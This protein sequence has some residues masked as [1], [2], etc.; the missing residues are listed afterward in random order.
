VP[1]ELAR[2]S[3]GQ[4]IEIP[5]LLV[6]VGVALLY[7]AVV[8]GSLGDRIPGRG[9]VRPR[10][11]AAFLTALGLL[12]LG[13]GGPLDV[14]AD[15]YLY[16][17][18]MTQH[19]LEAFGAA[20]LLLLGTPDW[21]VRPLWR[22]RLGG[23]LRFLT[24]PLVGMALFQ[25]VMALTA[26]PRFYDLIETSDAMH[27][28]YHAALLVTAL[29]AWWPFLSPLAE[30]PRMH[31]GMQMLMITVSGLPML[32]TFAPIAL[33]T[34]PFYPYYARVPRVF[35]LSQVADQQLGAIIMLTG[36]HVVAAVQFLEAFGQWVRQEQVGRIDA[37]PRR[38]ARPEGAGRVLTL[39]RPEWTT[40]E[41]DAGE[42]TTP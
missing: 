25:A 37:D 34:A 30:S 3:V 42:S 12:Y 7:L 5:V 1:P 15:G 20:P 27:F 31:P 22:S 16:S 11:V 9:P 41:A 29:G 35:G 21:L 36:A 14:L 13:F 40:P 24:R 19:F 39:A 6:N 17:A 26:W 28:G 4:W 2:L 38:R 8:R 32:L 23:V 33:D 18:H 10:Q